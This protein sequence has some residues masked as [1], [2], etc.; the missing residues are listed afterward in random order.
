MTPD[1]FITADSLDVTALIRDR[2]GSVSVVDQGGTTSD[3]AEIVLDDRSPCI[4]LPRKGARL[5]ISMGYVET[6]LAL[7]GEYTVDEVAINGP[8]KGL[9]IRARAADMRQSLKAPKTRSWDTIT[10][11][12]LVATIAAEHGY[13]AAVS[14]EFAGILLTHIDQT[15]ESDLHLLTRLAAERG[16]IAKPAGGYLLFVPR[17]QS[18]SVT[19]KVLPPVTMA[20]RDLSRYRVVMADRGKYQSVLAHWYD[21][22]GATPVPVTVGSGEPVFT[23]RNHFPDEESARGAAKAKLAA[24]E[25]GKAQLAV[26]MPGDNRLMADGRLV[27][28]EA[29]QGLAGEW[30]VTRVRHNS[31]GQGYSCEVEGEAP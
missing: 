24:F 25:R 17:G 26:T 1:Y 10:I 8:P 31:G 19:G 27:I 20:G 21:V 4:E 2:N 29:R 18:K 15:G 7:M 13:K 9:T 14:A 3:T 30:V 11:G 6:G 12:D 16:A 22:D 5:V 23:L 28:T